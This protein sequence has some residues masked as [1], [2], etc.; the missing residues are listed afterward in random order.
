MFLEEK[1]KLLSLRIHRILKV[2]L[3]TFRG[4]NE[5]E[6]SL[7]QLHFEKS[8][9]YM[10]LLFEKGGDSRTKKAENQMVCIVFI[11]LYVASD[12]CTM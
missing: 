12:I 7:I 9:G 11:V 10:L 6:I 8:H 3:R 4:E 2:N 1:L 5:N